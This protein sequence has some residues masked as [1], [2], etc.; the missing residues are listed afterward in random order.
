MRLSRTA[1]VGIGTILVGLVLFICTRYWIQTRTLFPLDMPVSL[2][3]G[4][5]GE[6]KINIRAFYSI[7]VVFPGGSEPNCSEYSVLR[8]RAISSIDGRIVTH[9]KSDHDVH[10]SSTTVGPFFG[11]F[12]SE[13]GR[14][15]LDIEVSSDARCLN[16]RSPHLEVIASSDDFTKWRDRYAD[17]FWISLSLVSVGMLVT[18]VAIFGAHRGPIGDT[19]NILGRNSNKS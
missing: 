14:Y 4:L 12:E 5:T 6:F 15:R 19:T 13:P 16:T 2:S 17:S 8:T 7:L 3:T 10:D 1:G 9:L 18:A 11:G